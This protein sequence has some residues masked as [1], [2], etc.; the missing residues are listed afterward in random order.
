LASDYIWTFTTGL[1]T[2]VTAPLLLSTAPTNSLTNVPVDVTITATFDEPMDPLTI[3]PLTFT[4][5][6]PTGT[7]VS[8]I[9]GSVTYFGNIATFNPTNDLESNAT[10]TVQ[11]AASDLAGNPWL[12][13]NVPNPWQFTTASSGLN[14]GIL[15]PFGIASYGG[16]TNSGATKINGDV[17]LHTTYTCNGVTILLGDG[18]GFG[19]C[20]GT[21]P[22]NNAGDVVITSIYPDTT[23][24]PAVMTQ[25]TAI[26]NSI[27]PA[28][29]PG[30]ADLACGTI[31]TGGGAGLGLG[32]AGNATLPPGIYKA[33][34]A[35]TI[36]ITGDLTLDAGGDA[37]AMF[38]FQAGSALT[39]SVGSQVILTGGAKASNVFWFVGS[40]ATINGNAVFN[41]NI[42]A[43]A[44]ISMGTGATSCGRL[45]AGAA[46]AG[47]FT[48]LSNT[49][50]VPGHASAPVG[51]E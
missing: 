44:S 32:C 26:W 1:T 46:G 7:I 11:I 37:N 29:L 10:Y 12:L 6:G 50:S 4:V 5:T 31:G 3:T 43:S 45:L 28:N 2:D 33:A 8:S 13:G 16:L 35:T 49:V 23:T 25:L 17:V 27:S 15:A 22:T 42:L 39:A 20:G 18:P 9:S 24:A 30:A 47:A 41:G 48:F 36:D 40:S 38:Y 21:P 34:S 19:L 51:C 14:L